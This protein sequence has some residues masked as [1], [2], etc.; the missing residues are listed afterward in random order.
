MKN[1]S[2][3]KFMNSEIT[4]IRTGDSIMMMVEDSMS[5]QNKG[6]FLITKPCV[7]W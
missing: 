4:I 2:M 3:I 7:I 1:I 6:Q 5:Y